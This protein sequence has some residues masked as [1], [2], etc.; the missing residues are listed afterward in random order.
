MLIE[1]L[2]QRGQVVDEIQRA[3]LALGLPFHDPQR[4]AELLSRIADL[5]GTYSADQIRQVFRLLFGASASSLG[6][7]PVGRWEFDA[8]VTACFD[9]M[10]ARSI[11]QYE[12]M[13]ELVTKL[14]ALHVRDHSDVVDL[15]CSRGESI[16]RL[17][18][19]V[20]PGARPSV[21]WW[22]CDVSQP[23][24][25][26]AQ[27]RLGDGVTVM[28][29]DLRSGTLR[30]LTASV[31]LLVLTMQFLPVN[32][33]SR[34]LR[35]IAA[36]TCAGGCLIVVE[37][38]QGENADMDELLVDTHHAFK[39]EAGYSEDEIRAKALALEN[40]LVPLSAAE[41]ERLL[42]AAGFRSVER[43]WQC[44]NFARWIAR[45]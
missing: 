6:H 10:L 22:G 28:P 3:K 23:M 25:A 12:V 33:R 32:H 4:E 11:P 38:I 31:T 1:L 17:R 42:R 24:L 27:A 2:Q 44:L 40:M 30:G 20:G 5:P 39:A 8:D 14:A 41:N 18:E 35:S 34:L 7:R 9:D 19:L 37:K 36:T 43:F 26:A 45:P 29:H 13:R 16:A 15:G 21:A